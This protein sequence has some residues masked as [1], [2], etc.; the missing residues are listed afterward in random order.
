LHSDDISDVELVDR[1]VR[2]HPGA[3]R[4]FYQRHS[5]L[6]YGCIRKRANAADVDDVFQAFFERLMAKEFRPLQLWQRGTSLPVY[7]A[8]VVR[9]FVVDFYRAKRFREDAVGGPA[10]IEAYLDPQEETQSLK[11]HLNELRHLGIQAWAALDERDRAMLCDR[12]HR[13]RTNDE[14]A[15]RFH[16]TPG[17]LRTALSRAQARLLGRL[18]TLA[19]EFFPDSV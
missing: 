14:I 5:Q 9:N 11:G 8:K 15:E 10:E 7:L 16:L 2:G 12:F 3:F 17:A 4:Q 6:I 18:K 1:V 13:D 19:P